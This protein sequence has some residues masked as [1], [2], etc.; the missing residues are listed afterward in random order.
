MTM[1]KTKTTSSIPRQYSLIRQTKEWDGETFKKGQMFIY[2]GEIP[3]MPEHCVIV[4]AGG[5]WGKT[6][7]GVHTERFEEVP[8]DET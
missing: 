8:E 1:R 5:K 2:L 6:L 3:N 7:V 4:T